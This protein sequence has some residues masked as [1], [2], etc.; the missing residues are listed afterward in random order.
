MGQDLGESR[1]HLSPLSLDVCGCNF[2][3]S[4]GVVRTYI[5][6]LSEAVVILEVTI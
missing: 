5:F 4:V 3:G 1:C 2:G 6:Y